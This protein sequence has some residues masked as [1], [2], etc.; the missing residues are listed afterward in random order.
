[1]SLRPPD[2]PASLPVPVPDAPRI[3]WPLSRQILLPVGGLL[4]LAVAVNTMAAAW[5]SSRRTALAAAERQ[6]QV[7]QVLAEANYPRSGSVLRQLS[8]LTGD[9]YVT[10]DARRKV[11]LATSLPTIDELELPLSQ[12]NSDA[13]G[14][15][16]VTTSDQDFWAAVVPAGPSAPDQQI[17][18][19]TTAERWTRSRWLA[20]W[21][22][23]AF[24]AATLLGLVPLTVWLSRRLSRRVQ[25][26]QTHVAEIASGNFG[27]TIALGG[28]DDEVRRLADR[29]NHLSLELRQLRDTLIHSERMRVLAQL[30]AGVAHQ[31]R[32]GLTGARLAIQ[33]HARRCS[34][35]T[36]DGS[37]QV[38]LSQLT[39]L[40]EEVR[41]LLSLGR[42]DAEV[43]RP[44]DLTALLEN[45]A[46][47][48][49]PV[50]EHTGV[51]LQWV[52]SENT[53]TAVARRDALRAAIL[54]LVLNAVEAAGTGGVLT[55]QAD[56]HGG[57]A[58][59][60][61]T[62]TGPGPATEVA[63]T[64]FDPFTTTKPEGLGLGLAIARQVAEDH[65]GGL[66][67]NRVNSQTCF[68]LHWPAD[69]SFVDEPHPDRR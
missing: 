10:W 40:E 24:G 45:V 69:G 47:L 13:G 6:Q 67:W 46:E 1:M 18:V 29:V 51:T 2:V 26:L 34:A 65:H 56:V 35:T 25:Q 8:Q 59:V 31:L 21:P 28:P 42:R 37:L 27:Q 33:L 58:S 36:T 38:A 4:L 54:N 64:L 16:R 50:C 19:L 3:N 32:N 41:G 49:Q 43:S 15:Q 57:R 17:F 7:A 60:R 48:V 22:S 44:L 62:D 61:V 11:A 66:S 55:L 53:L 12:V 20:V 68:E 23:L 5:M 14:L 30:A 9:H 63:G 52:R 39:L